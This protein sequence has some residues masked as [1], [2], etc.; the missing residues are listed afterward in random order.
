MEEKVRHFREVCRKNGLK[1]TPQRGAIYRELVS[2]KRHPSAS[3]ICRKIESYFPNIS[4]GTVNSTLLAFARIGL[5]R[6]VESSGDPKR[7]DPNLRPHHHFRCITCGKIVDF[8]SDSYDGLEVP[9]KIKKRFLVLSK[10]VHLE[11]LCDKCRI[12]SKT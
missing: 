10:M 11:G 12:E 5:S 1:V 7:F 2:S 9:A 6:I 8:Y 3:M 4:L